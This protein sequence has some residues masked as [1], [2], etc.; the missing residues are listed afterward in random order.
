M[1]KEVKRHDVNTGTTELQ[2]ICSGQIKLDS[3]WGFMAYQDRSKKTG[4]N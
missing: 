3:V 1:G 2:G 4:L